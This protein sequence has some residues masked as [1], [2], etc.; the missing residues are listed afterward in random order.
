MA[1]PISL[2]EARRRS[3]KGDKPPEQ[4]QADDPC[5]VTALGHI[6]GRFWFLNADG[7]RRALSASQM[8]RRP[9]LA[10]L[11][12][13]DVGWLMRVFPQLGDDGTAKGFSVAKAGDF[14]MRLCRERGLYGQ[15]VLV[16][17]EGVWRGV[18][19]DPIAHCGDVVFS[20]EQMHPAGVSLAGQIFAATAP[21]PRPADRP[22]P[23]EVAQ[24]IVADIGELWN[25]RDGGGPIIAVGLVGAAYYAAAIDW[26]PNGFITGPSNAGKS[27][28][29]DVLRHMTVL[30]H[31]STDT[32][33]AGIE[34]AV[35]GR[36]LPVFLDEASDREGDGVKNLLDVVL[37]ASSG[38]GTRLHRGTADGAGRS[39][40]V[41]A[42]VIMASVS[43]PAMLPQ[44]RSRFALIEL[45]KPESG[46]DHRA[47]MQSLTKRAK[48]A[49]PALFARALQNLRL[50]RLALERFRAALGRAGCVAREMDQLGAILAGW[51]MLVENE[52]PND[53]QAS[54]TVKA[55]A[56]FIRG[57]EIMDEEDA[58]NQVLSIL[59]SRVVNLDRSTDQDSIARLIEHAL[60]TESETDSMRQAALRVLERW[61]MRVVRQSDETDRRGF[62][63]PRLGAGDGIWINPRVEGLK[64]VFNGTPFAGER[65]LTELRRL[66]SAKF[67]R[68]N[69]RVGALPPGKC[70]WIGWDRSNDPPG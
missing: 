52:P 51:W 3:R 31:Y 65:W 67:S 57:A 40:E 16:R 45:T 66:E 15:H 34:S 21:R 64:T 11:F 58:P 61:G 37:S 30:S 8:G 10:G 9:E 29:L 69:V 48:Q 4:A 36:A 5:P 59:L 62:P 20:G 68:S 1:E 46:V 26:R 2:T 56:N 12:L 27:H 18:A 70:I 14:L 44:H 7:E 54:V 63:V 39:V 17:Q 47:Q 25:F 38:E 28:L 32:T 60:S 19:D 42:S 50:Y 22:A 24:E 41:C 49:A 33:K 55:I 53:A 13:G 23:V 6:D 43:P 35:N